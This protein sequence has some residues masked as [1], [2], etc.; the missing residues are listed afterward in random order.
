MSPNLRVYS[1][2][3]GTIS[4]SK[5]KREQESIQQISRRHRKVAPKKRK[6]PR[7]AGYATEEGLTCY[8]RKDLAA[9]IRFAP[10]ENTRNRYRPLGRRI[11]CKFCSRDKVMHTCLACG[12]FFCMAPPYNLN[13]PGS[14]PPRKFATNGPFC[15]QLI[16]GYQTWASFAKDQNVA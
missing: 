15:W 3:R 2:K 12:E 7:V 16:H 5:R 13:I 10:D 11:R 6:R 8:G 9:W 1:M 14:N 4:G